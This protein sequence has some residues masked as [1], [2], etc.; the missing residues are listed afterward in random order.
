VFFRTGGVRETIRDY[1]L[2]LPYTVELKRGG[3]GYRASIKELPEC[4]A[5]VPAS[6][7]VEKLWQRLENA[8]RKWIEQ[9]LEIGREVPEP[10]SATK[11][12]FWDEFEEG[13]P[14]YREGKLGLRCMSMGSLAFLSVSSRSCGCR[15]WET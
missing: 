9:E 14:N 8:Q 1:Y 5:T 13:N 15:N 4:T 11:D 2:S 10:P 3:E 12:P 6:E 7:S